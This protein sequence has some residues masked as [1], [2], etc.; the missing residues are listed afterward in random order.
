MMQLSCIDVVVAVVDDDDDD[1]DDDDF[2][3]FF[4]HLIKALVN[5]IDSMDHGIHR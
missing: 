2:V 5:H 3:K 1:D 4:I